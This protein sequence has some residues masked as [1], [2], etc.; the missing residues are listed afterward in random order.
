MNKD[1]LGIR[2]LTKL[3]IIHLIDQARQIKKNPK[4]YSKSLFEKVLLLFFEQPSLR[5][6]ISFETAI[7][8]MGGE[9]IDYHTENSPWKIGKETL[10]DVAK[11]ISQYCDIAAL[12]IFDHKD[13]EKFAKNSKIP[14]IN[15]MTNQEHPCQILGDL[16]TILEK[17]KKLNGLTLAYIGDSNNN[18]THSLMYG[19]SKLGIK[20]NIACPK[21]REFM[22]AA[23]VV[24]ESKK[25]AES[26]NSSVNIYNNAMKA[27]KNADI[28]YTDS[29]MSYRIPK[30]ERP[31]R[32]KILKKFQV[33]SKLMKKAKKDAVFMHCMPA[34]RGDEAT[35]EVIDGKK[36]IILEQAKNRLYTEKAILLKLLK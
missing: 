4:K 10:E 15:A 24:K 7:F 32:I 12:R 28:I 1:L 6:E 34:K 18:V 30:E 33:N 17:K 11:V 31:R 25:L 27:V 35:K 29:W 8:Q 23:F 19:C 14:I 13:L 26:N 22:P 36:S 21:M 3:E 20:I 5:T 16:M 2:D 9:A